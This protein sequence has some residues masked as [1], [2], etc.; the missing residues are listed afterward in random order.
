LVK[1]IDLNLE[2]SASDHKAD[3]DSITNS[4]FG[5]FK[6]KEELLATFPNLE[7]V[8]DIPLDVRDGWNP[9]APTRRAGTLQITRTDGQL[10]LRPDRTLEMGYS[11]KPSFLFP[12]LASARTEYDLVDYFRD[13]GG[14]TYLYAPPYTRSMVRGDSHKSGAWSVDEYAGH[15]QRTHIDSYET[16]IT[17]MK[18][19][20]DRTSNEVSHYTGLASALYKDGTIGVSGATRVGYSRKDEYRWPTDIA[21]L[22]N[23]PRRLLPG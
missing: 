10:T 13:D 23:S 20:L 19:Q 6:N 8:Y 2:Y 5:A 1:A 7:R 3:P 15:L 9:S 4:M 14:I 22:S 21:C 12:I 18:L 16:P 17:C 11:V